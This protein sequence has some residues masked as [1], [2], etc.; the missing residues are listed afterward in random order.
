M[1]RP[2]F[3][4]RS[5]FAVSV[6][7]CR[8]GPRAKETASMRRDMFI[9]RLRTAITAI[10]ERLE[11]FIGDEVARQPDPEP[12]SRWLRLPK[13]EIRAAVA[14][15]EA[16]GEVAEAEH[17]HELCKLAREYNALLW[18]ARSS[19]A[20]EPI[21]QEWASQ[22]YRYAE[23]IRDHLRHVESGLMT[24]GEYADACQR[25]EAIWKQLM[26]DNGRLFSVRARALGN[27]TTAVDATRDREIVEPC[28]L[29]RKGGVWELQYGKEQGAF[30]A[31]DFAALQ[32][33][34]KLLASP[35]RLFHL[36]ELSAPETRAL[37]D[38]DD[39]ACPSPVIDGEAMTAYKRRYDDLQRQRATQ[40]D[41]QTLA[42]IDEEMGAL[43]NEVRR[44]TGLGGRRRPLGRTQADRAWESLR[45]S[46][47][48]LWRR[49]AD[50]NMPSLSS[51]LKQAIVF[52]GR[53][54]AY[55]AA[56]GSAWDVAL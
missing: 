12:A 39:N 34:A 44:N 6:A 14:C 9:P 19:L 11:A 43:A 49:L 5:P 51:H 3:A 20:R 10:L 33:L 52:A 25:G 38:A 32:T 27:A 42:K 24:P 13:A 36:T 50:Y 23:M 45:K 48:R 16:I 29:R 41:P 2:G 46:L 15:L 54:V 47:S 1:N 22:R 26:E 17:L 37:L 7:V 4:R 31:R 8:A 53:R 55:D 40:D 18:D 56:P 35:G 28:H 30:P 21:A